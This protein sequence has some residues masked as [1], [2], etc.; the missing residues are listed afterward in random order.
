MTPLTDSMFKPLIPSTFYTGFPKNF[1]QNL[2]INIFS[3]GIIPSIESVV[4][5]GRLTFLKSQGKVLVEKENEFMQAANQLENACHKTFAECLEGEN[6]EPSKVL[7]SKHHLSLAELEKNPGL[8]NPAPAKKEWTALILKISQTVIH[9]FSRLLLNIVTIG[10]YGVRENFSLDCQIAKEEAQNKTMESLFNT[11]YPARLKEIAKW[12][13][14]INQTTILSSSTNEAQLYAYQKQKEVQKL[15]QLHQVELQRISDLVSSQAQLKN[16]YSDLSQENS[17]LHVAIIKQ[18]DETKQ[19]IKQIDSLTKTIH[20]LNETIKADKD[21]YEKEKQVFQKQKTKYEFLKLSE[22][23]KDQLIEPLKTL[24]SKKNP[25]YHDILKSAAALTKDLGP[26]PSKYK[27]RPEDGPMYGAMDIDESS[28]QDWVKTRNIDGLKTYNFR[29]GNLKAAS[30]VVQVSFQY[31]FQLLLDLAEH[32][33]DQSHSQDKRPDPKIH[34]NKSCE[35]L[36]TLSGEVIY[37]IMILDILQGAQVFDNGCK[38]YDLKVNPDIILRSSKP[39]KVLKQVDSNTPEVVVELS[40]TDDF[41]PSHAVLSFAG[42]KE[43]VDPLSAKWI[44]SRLTGTDHYHLLNKL[45]DPLIEDT[46]PSLLSTKNYLKTCPSDRAALI[47]TAYSLIVDLGVAIRL[48]F[49]SNVLVRHWQTLADESVDPFIKDKEIAKLTNCSEESLMVKESD[50]FVETY[51][52]IDVL[53]DKDPKT[54]KLRQ[55]DFYDLVAFAHDQFRS[56][57]N[58]LSEGILR[59]PIKV[60]KDENLIISKLKWNLVNEQYHVSHLMIGSD[61]WENLGTQRC[62]FSNLLGIIMRDKKHVTDS[63]AMK[64]RNAMSAYLDKLMNAKLKA[65]LGK[66]Q[67]DVP[68]PKELAELAELAQH[69]EKGISSAHKNCSVAEYQKWLRGGASKKIIAS[70]LTPFEIQLAAH[71]I[72]IKIGLLGIESNSAARVDEFGRIVPIAEYYGPNTKH[73][74]LMGINATV[75]SAGSYYGLFPKL[76]VESDEVQK[77]LMADDYANLFELESYWNSIKMKKK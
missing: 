63:N 31:A 70:D 68:I 33:P 45:M 50:P 30:E 42:I 57:F 5:T 46:D 20:E 69:F 44:L 7:A 53:G 37:R 71:T 58:N 23:S 73:F 77:K 55:S 64:L 47:E 66:L 14:K 25:T 15:Q 67:K 51:L 21:R 60:E 61:G 76:N 36:G 59:H 43:G 72:G 4:L 75:D 17:G 48:K 22:A 1:F 9:F 12:I 38:G 8:N 19:K 41:T 39:A 13:D 32:G 26:L 3:F 40:Q 6:S 49:Q 27:K 24:S 10:I 16:K 34:F 11:K 56:V 2:A 29:Y 65:G 28:A 35:M 52:D 62:L 54:G 18:K 74:L